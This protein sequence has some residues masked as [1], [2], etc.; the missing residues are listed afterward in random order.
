MPIADLPNILLLWHHLEP[1]IGRVKMV[2]GLAGMRKRRSL[3]W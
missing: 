2:A 1:A 3:V